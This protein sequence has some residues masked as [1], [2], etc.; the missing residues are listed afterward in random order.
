M[1]LLNLAMLDTLIDPVSE[2]QNP[3]LYGE[4]T[5]LVMCEPELSLTV[6]LSKNT[7]LLPQVVD[8][9]ESAPVFHPATITSS[10]CSGGLNIR[11]SY[12]TELQQR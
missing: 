3:A 6:K 1:I 11:Q 4:A 9:S 2:V 12:R 7:V 5:S 10:I 8:R